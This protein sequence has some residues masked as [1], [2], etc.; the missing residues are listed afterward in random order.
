MIDFQLRYVPSNLREV[1][2]DAPR[3]LRGVVTEEAAKYLIGDARRGLKHYDPYRYVTRAAAYG[4]SFFSLA[5]QR[6]V[7][8]M[9]AQGLITPGTAQRSGAT[10]AG[11]T[12]LYAGVHTRIINITRG[13]YYTRDDMGQSRHEQMV[14]HK[15]VREVIASNER[16]MEQAVD[17]T[18]QQ[19][20]RAKGL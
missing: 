6:Y 20:L 2:S 13:A 9:I 10:A 15:K 18:V 16:G 17:R 19:W 3:H 7:M 11:W 1:I 8:A 14:G 12:I 4:V 5:Q